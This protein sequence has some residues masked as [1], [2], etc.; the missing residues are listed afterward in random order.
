[1]KRFFKL[2]K[3]DISFNASI[4]IE[5]LRLRLS[6]WVSP[7]CHDKWKHVYHFSR[8]TSVFGYEGKEDEF[9]EQI[10]KMMKILLD[11]NNIIYLYT[12]TPEPKKRYKCE[13]IYMN[14]KFIITG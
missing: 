6:L 7:F 9:N 4:F 8:R 5:K 14:K 12:I 11:D 10:F 2:L 1:M 13:I 3:M